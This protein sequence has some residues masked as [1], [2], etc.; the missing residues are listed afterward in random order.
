[1]RSRYACTNVWQVSDLSRKAC[2]MLET[3]ASSIWKLSA[4]ARVAAI[5]ASPAKHKH[6][7]D[8]IGEPLKAATL[9]NS[10][11]HSSYGA[12]REETGQVCWRGAE[13]ALG[14]EVSFQ[15]LRGM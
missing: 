7:I 14:G 4:P 6:A 2:W 8:F 12:I 5:A 15:S 11:A 3:V 13:P 9:S 10:A 1:M